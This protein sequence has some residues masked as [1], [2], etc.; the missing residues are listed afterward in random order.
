[1]E[2]LSLTSHSYSLTY[3]LYSWTFSLFTHTLDYGYAHI[4]M[5]LYNYLYISLYIY[6][7]PYLY[8]HYIIY[9]FIFSNFR[10]HPLWAYYHHICSIVCTYTYF[11][12]I[13]MHQGLVPPHL[14]SKTIGFLAI[15]PPTM[16]SYCINKTLVAVHD[17][18]KAV[19]AREHPMRERSLTI[20]FLFLLFFPCN[21]ITSHFHKLY[22]SS[23]SSKLS[24]QEEG[25]RGRFSTCGTLAQDI[26]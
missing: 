16:A 20:K 11:V 2:S 22:K 12:Y 17:K 5:M 8:T 24:F 19:S 25:S 6:V 26:S 21:V 15:G 7:S 4:Y 3:T 13:I 23:L 14:A 1:M 18:S 9:N 10:I